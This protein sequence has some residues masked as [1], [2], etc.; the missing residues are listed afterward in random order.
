MDAVS[1]ALE[2]HKVELL[3]TSPTYINLILLSEAYKRHK[4]DSLKIVTYGTEPMPE[5]TLKRF[6]KLF[7]KIRIL[8]T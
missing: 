5:S 4:I 8:Q 3:P 1:S 6:H 2:K 7:P